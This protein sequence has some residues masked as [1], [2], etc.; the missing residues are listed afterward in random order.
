MVA[1][2]TLIVV[3][4]FVGRLFLTASAL[5]NWWLA[6]A[7]VAA[8]LALY[9]LPRWAGISVAAGIRSL[10]RVAAD[11][12]TFLIGAFLI[13]L[14]YCVPTFLSWS[15]RRDR[16]WKSLALF[17]AVLS[18][19]F[20]ADLRFGAP[21]VTPLFSVDL[22]F[23]IGLA[24]FVALRSDVFERGDDSPSPT[25]TWQETRSHRRRAG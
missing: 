21:D 6:C 14:G 17:L 9:A 4:A 22:W 7:V 12:G 25:E 23:G 5:R 24:A 10:I 19:A 16:R 1:A 2:I 8:A 3:I 15:D 18:G 11:V 20:V 13:V